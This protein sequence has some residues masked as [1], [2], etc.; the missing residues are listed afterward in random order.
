MFKDLLKEMEKLKKTSFSVPIEIDEKG[1]LD[2][3]CPSEECLFQFKVN[4]D[5]W[6]EICKDEAIW[7]PLCRHEAPS[8]HWY[9]LEHIEHGKSEA[10]AVLEGR[11]HNAMKSGAQKFNRSQSKNSF[12][13]MSLEVKGGKKRTHVIPARAAEEMQLDIQCEACMTRFAV[14]GSAYFCPACGHNSV[15]QTYSD[16][17]RKIRAKKNN[18]ETVREALTSS[19][20]K[21]D[22]EL[23]CRSLIETCISDGVVAFQKYCEGLYA[24]FGP[25]PRNAFQRLKHG[26]DLWFKAVQKKYDDWLSPDELLGLAVLFQK[27]HILAHNEGIVDADYLK[28]SGDTVYREGQRIVVSERDIN[29]LLSALDKLGNG[30]KAACQSIED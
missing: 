6:S 22:A 23:T 29:D 21:D 27:R 7:C 15:L 17:L 1:Y 25:A 2:R 20:G 24:P 19:V 5:D 18:V 28:K 30:L 14:I 16:S 11:I 8:D 13:S 26:S 10:M 3:Q 4:Q 9:T 12:I